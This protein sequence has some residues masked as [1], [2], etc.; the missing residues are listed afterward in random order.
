M[1]PGP[2]VVGT[3]TVAQAAA[4]AGVR[5]LVLA[6]SLHAVSAVSALPGQAQAQVPTR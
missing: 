5:R 2:N 4:R 1:L 3:V 6:S